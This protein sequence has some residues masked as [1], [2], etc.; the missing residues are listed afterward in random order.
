[1]TQQT[2]Q[3]H[4]TV[5]DQKQGDSALMVI[6]WKTSGMIPVELRG[7]GKQQKSP[8]ILDAPTKR[9][10]GAGGHCSSASPSLMWDARQRNRP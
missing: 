2:E 10:E 5:S 3:S 1:M 4:S 8:K 6:I 9:Y 7:A